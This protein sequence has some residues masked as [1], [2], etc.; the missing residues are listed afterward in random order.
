MLLLFQFLPDLGLPLTVRPVLA[1]TQIGA[2][3]AVLCALTRVSFFS[4]VLFLAICVPSLIEYLYLTG[5]I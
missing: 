5:G 4:G 3:L 2:F 1:K